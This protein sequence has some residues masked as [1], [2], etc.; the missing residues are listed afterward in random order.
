MLYCSGIAPLGKTV[1]KLLSIT[2]WTISARNWQ[3]LAR[4]RDREK[5]VLGAA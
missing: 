3:L 1:V 5:I 4:I 2:F